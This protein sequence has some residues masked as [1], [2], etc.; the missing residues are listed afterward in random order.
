MQYKYEVRPRAARK[1]WSFFR[2]V[3][4]KYRHTFDTE[5][6]VKNAQRAIR[7]MGLIEQSLLRRKPVIEQWKKEGWHMANAGKWY[8][9]Y[10][11]ANDS[12]IIEDACHSQNVH[13]ES[14]LEK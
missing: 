3:A 1:I 2:H 9:A 13:E 12:I 6:I 14:Q 5:D 4:L 11:I 8:Y 10:T 7:N